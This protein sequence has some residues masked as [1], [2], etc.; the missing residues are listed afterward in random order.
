[1]IDDKPINNTLKTSANELLAVNKIPIC[2]VLP[3]D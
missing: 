3:L 1:M 2:L